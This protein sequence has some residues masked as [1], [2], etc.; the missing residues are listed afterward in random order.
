MA[1]LKESYV[2]TVLILQEVPLHP[3]T[4]LTRL[5][6]CFEKPSIVHVTRKDGL[7][8]YTQRPIYD[9]YYLVIF[10]DVRVLESC[11][12]S[13]R[14]DFMLP[15][16]LCS[17]KNSVESAKEVCQN[18]GLKYSVYVNAFTKD[19]ASEMI[20][21]LASVKVSDEFCKALIKRVGLSPQRI[22]SAVMVCEQVGYTTSSISKYVDKYTYI[23]I[24]DVL[25]SLLHICKSGAQMKRA[26]LY[27]HTNRLWYNKYTRANLIKEVDTIIKIYR[28]LL[29]GELTAYSMQEYEMSEH[30]PRYRLLYAIDLFEQISLNELLALK[31]FISTASLLEVVLKLS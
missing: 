20:R 3:H 22:I 1:T 26:A 5:E 19:V 31:Q 25:E 23:D 7:R 24:Y 21:N 4:V 15:V 28:A 29:T 13:I 18:K 8:A 10:E 30:I 12:S 27:L 17:S 6:D 11:S 2:S 14:L 16:M 9:D